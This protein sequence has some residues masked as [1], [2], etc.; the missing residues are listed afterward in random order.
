MTNNLLGGVVIAELLVEV[1]VVMV[2]VDIVEVELV[3]DVVV[4][5]V[6]FD[7]VEEVVEELIALE[8]D[9]IGEVDT[10]G[11]TKIVMLR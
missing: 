4:S 2:V 1:N 6:S 5:L 3:I 11:I 9:E 8:L 7:V 10:V